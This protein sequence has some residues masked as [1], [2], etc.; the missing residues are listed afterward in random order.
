M[1]DSENREVGTLETVLGTGTFI[2]GFLCAWHGMNETIDFI[3]QATQDPEMMRMIPETLLR[4]HE[5]PIISKIVYS[6]LVGYITGGIAG[7]IGRGL[8]WTIK[9]YQ[10]RHEHLWPGF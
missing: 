7:F 3:S 4:I 2:F 5:Y 1:K 8:D 10:T 9:K 6:G